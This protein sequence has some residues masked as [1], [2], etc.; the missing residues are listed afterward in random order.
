MFCFNYQ[1]NKDDQKKFYCKSRYKIIREIRICIHIDDN[2]IKLYKPLGLN[3]DSTSQRIFGQ[4][5][6]SRFEVESKNI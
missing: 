1:S 2:L 3:L 5:N 6:L 4:S